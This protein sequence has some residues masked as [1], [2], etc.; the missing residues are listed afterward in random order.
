M[1]KLCRYSAESGQTHKAVLLD[2]DGVLWEDNG[3]GTILQ[4]RRVAPPVVE[5]LERARSVLGPEIRLIVLSN[6]T[7]VARGMCTEETLSSSFEALLLSTGLV[8]GVYLSLSHPE[9]SVPRYRRQS[10][11]RKP[12]IGMFEAAKR[13]WG[14][15]M[16]NCVMIGD[17]ITDMLAAVSSGV[18]QAF[19][20]VGRQSFD[21]NVHSQNLSGSFMQAQFNAIG[22]LLEIDWHWFK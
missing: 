9:A 11:S 15:T 7:C 2:A 14:L 22:S 20:I 21:L 4:I 16:S 18:S 17:R 13:D 5:T 12:S 1:L 19:L 6:Q 3:P 8:D 10:E